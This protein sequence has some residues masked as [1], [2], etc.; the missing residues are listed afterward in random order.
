MRMNARRT[1]RLAVTLGV[2]LACLV[3]AS[4]AHAQS[5][6]NQLGRAGAE[7]FAAGCAN[8]GC[9][10]NICGHNVQYNSGTS[11]ITVPDL[12]I[13]NVN[14]GTSGA[15]G[16]NA[17]AVA[18]A[19]NVYCGSNAGD[20]LLATGGSQHMQG[21]QMESVTRALRGPS[22]GSIFGGG[23]SGEISSTT[24]GV[25]VPLDYSARLSPDRAFTMVGF[26]TFANQGNANQEGIS[27]SPALAWSINNDEGNKVLNIAAYVPLSFA[28]AEVSNVPNGT[29]ISWG[30]GG[31]AL[32]TIP[33]HVRATQIN[34]GAGVAG[35]ETAAGFSLPLSAIARVEQPLE[36]TSRVK[37]YTSLSYGNDFINAGSEVWTL[38]LGITLGKYDF[39]YRGFYGNA[40]VAHTIGFSIRNDVEEA[41]E[42]LPPE[43]TAT[44]ATPAGPPAP[45]AP[46]E[47]SPTA[48]PTPPPP[49]PSPTVEPPAPEVAPPPPPTTAPPPPPPGS[50]PIIPDDPD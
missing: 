43:P 22:T 31:G 7:F 6:L 27:A 14:V 39:G 32:A 26:L 21:T 18:N 4:P 11:N 41:V 3:V 1:A 40:Y 49:P 35:R 2:A 33:F 45:P 28:V 44:P 34:V 25:S 20:S 50:V 5:V 47:P 48:A 9:N 30:A 15:A 42:H 10:T 23:G 29:L 8:N 37:A 38:A 19:L 17:I 24:Y 13:N 12:G 36:F 16:S 46:V